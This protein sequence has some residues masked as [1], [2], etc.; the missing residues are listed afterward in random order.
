MRGTGSLLAPQRHPAVGHALPEGKGWPTAGLGGPPMGQP[1]FGVD[2]ARL[3]RFRVKNTFGRADGRVWWVPAMPTAWAPRN[4]GSSLISGGAAI[5]GVV[6][7]YF[8]PLAASDAAGLIWPWSTGTKS[9]KWSS[10]PAK[11]DRF[12]LMTTFPPSASDS[13]ARERDLFEIDHARGAAG[14]DHQPEVIA[15]IDRAVPVNVTD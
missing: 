10:N 3:G 8:C 12:S 2:R 1:C 14:V 13:R 15:E 6:E 5:D 11:L 4:D 7:W 9:P